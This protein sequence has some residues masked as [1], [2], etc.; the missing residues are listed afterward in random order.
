MENFSCYNW[1]KTLEK[2]N[3]LLSF[4]GEFNHDLI[5]ALLILTEMKT[6]G[7]GDG[8]VQ[9]KVFGVIVECLQ[10]I[11]KHGAPHNETN[12]LNPGIMLLG[13]TNDDY[14]LHVGNM[15]LNENVEKLK[16]KIDELNHMSEQELRDKQQHILKTTSLSSEGNAGIGLIYIKRKIKG[17]MMYKFKPINDKVSFYALSLT[18]SVQK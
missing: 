8:K 4:K 7:I 14:L 3:L 16:N 11:Y 12:A 15:V 6:E 13:K 9:S 5:K 18:V 2:E 17:N 1:Y 10:N